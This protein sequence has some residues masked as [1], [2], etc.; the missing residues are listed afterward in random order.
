L[1]L[2]EP[3]NGLDDAR[4]ADAIALVR[5]VHRAFALPMVLVSH[6][7]EEV[8]ALAT[9]VIALEGG[10]LVAPAASDPAR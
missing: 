1:L 7:R 9:Q 3:F 2:D 5:D 6:R 10:R 4:R 8:D